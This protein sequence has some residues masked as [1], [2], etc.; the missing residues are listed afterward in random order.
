M[1]T[2]FIDRDG[3]IN[4]K[5]P[6]DY[7]KN[8]EEF[9]FLPG[10][11]EALAVLDKHFDRIFIVTNQRGVGR[12]IMTRETL[13]DIHTRMLQEIRAQGGRIDKIYVCTDIDSPN[14]K[15]NIGMALQAAKDYPEI[16]FE[17]STMLGDS[18]SDMKF[19]RNTGMTTVF[20]G[21]KDDVEEKDLP[22]IDCFFKS[23]LSFA[24]QL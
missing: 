8:R 17:E 1:K 16:V 15:P 10:V 6:G 22:L 7:V 12:G 3:V 14:R 24:Q 5:R 23:L 18:I 19:G 2:I 13:D 21:K 4:R 20:I 9:I 11:T